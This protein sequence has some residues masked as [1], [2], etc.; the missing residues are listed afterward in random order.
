YPTIWTQAGSPRKRHFAP[1][2]QVKSNGVTKL[3]LLLG[4]RGSRT[5][6][7][8]ENTIA[9]FESALQHGCD[10]FEFDVRLTRDGQAV[11]CHN[12]RS[13]GKLLV[14]NQAAHFQHL[15]TLTDVIDRFCNRAFLDIE[16]KVAGLEQVVQT[17]LLEHPPQA[18]YLV[19]SFLPEAL[20]ALRARSETVPLGFIFD[21]KTARWRD[22]PVNYVIP[23]K[24]LV[25]PNL[26]AEVHERG[27]QIMTWTVN[28]RCSMLRFAELGVDG[29]I[30]D[31][32]DLLVKTLRPHAG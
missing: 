19:S 23:H 11:I 27:K 17:A 22:L 4:H 16:L 10:G 15:P 32:T 24:S 2:S 7:C 29:I 31:K 14:K 1:C 25:T 13:R 5:R 18:G 21:K 9:A 6:G 8:R 3:P 20:I 28:D 12:P 30:S 26:I